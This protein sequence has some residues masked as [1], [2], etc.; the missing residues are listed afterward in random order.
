MGYVVVRGGEVDWSVVGPLYGGCVAWTLVYDT[1]Y[2]H[3]DKADDAK[4]GLK[5]TALTFGERGTRP[6]LTVLTGATW[7]GW[8]IAGY[9]CGFGEVLDAPY[10]YAGVSTAG[11]HFLWQI[12]TADLN[13]SENLAYRFRSNNAVRWI[14]FGSCVA[15]NVMAG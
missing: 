5:S 11:A 12:H 6:I 8:M 1:L 2:A 13:Y 7:A 14:M 10:Y 15:G 3:Q 9:N 4:L